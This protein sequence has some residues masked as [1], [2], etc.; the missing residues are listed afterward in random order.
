MAGNRHLRKGYQEWLE[1][2]HG[3]ETGRSGRPGGKGD[4]DDGNDDDD[5][6]GERP[7]ESLGRSPA[8][9][10]APSRL[11]A[12]RCSQPNRE[13]AHAGNTP[14]AS[15]SSGRG[16]RDG[17]STVGA[18]AAPRRRGGARRRRRAIP[19]RHDARDD[20]GVS[21]SVGGTARI[22]AGSR[23]PAAT[24]AAPAP[25]RGKT[26]GTRARPHRIRTDPSSEWRLSVDGGVGGGGERGSVPVPGASAPGGMGTSGNG[27]AVVSDD[28]EETA[29][30]R[31]ACS[32]EDSL[33]LPVSRPEG[34]QR[35]SRGRKASVSG[36]SSRK[37]MRVDTSGV[38]KV[39]DDGS[40]AVPPQG[41]SDV[42]AVREDSRGAASG[43]GSHFRKR[44]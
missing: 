11:A 4:S 30:G 24:P 26:R 32:G 43:T 16:T 34:R 17:A 36:S 39:V 29:T 38:A 2:I 6:D 27:V 1:T 22:S 5:D 25:A 3:H 31:E 35:H 13:R 14:E 42:R 8:T 7:E 37:R 10:T 19:A 40:P 9:G 33:S 23:P 41:A 15:A 21:E 44:R 18:D 28:A 12:R 20:A